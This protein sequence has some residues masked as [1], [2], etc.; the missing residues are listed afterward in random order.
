MVWITCL[1]AAAA[2]TLLIAGIAVAQEVPYS[3]IEPA[4]SRAIPIGPVPHPPGFGFR[5]LAGGAHLKGEREVLADYTRFHLPAPPQGYEWVQ[6]RGNFVLIA[7]STGII[8][9][10]VVASN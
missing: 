7:I 2:A 4:N 3:Q 1:K 5:N 6:S 9:N 8:A 10:I